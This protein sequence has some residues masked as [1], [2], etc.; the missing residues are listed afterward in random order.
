MARRDTQAINVGTNP[1]DGTGEPIRE[2]FIKVNDSF[3]NI[4]QRLIDGNLPI[5]VSNVITSNNATISN[6]TVTD[7]ATINPTV[8]LTINPSVIGSIDNTRIGQNT[9]RPGT[10][11]TLTAD[12]ITS[13][14]VVNIIGNLVV[15][16]NVVTQSSSDLVILDSII[17]LHTTAGLTPLTV[18]DGKDIGI[19]FHYYKSG[20]N[21]AFLGWANDTGSLE[22]YAAGN[23]SG[24]VFV[25]TSY[26][27]IKAGGFLSTN[28]TPSTSTSTGAIVTSGG[29]GVAGAIY[30]GSLNTGSGAITG[31]AITGTSSNMTTIY[32]TNFS[33]GNA[34][35][36]GGS[37]SGVSGA[38]GTLVVTNFS[39]GNAQISG[40]RAEGL[41][42]LNAT[43]FSTSNAQIGGGTISAMTSLTATTGSF[44]N[45]YTTNFSS[46]NVLISGGSLNGTS[47]G[48]TTAST[49]RFTTVSATTSVASPSYLWSTNSI[50]ILDSVN[51]EITNLWSNIS[52]LSSGAGSSAT[53]ITNLW[54]NAASQA[55]SINTLTSNAA[56]QATA[57]NTLDA[58]LGTA[59]TNITTLFSNA[60]T[61]STAIA[62]KAPIDN[63]SFTTHVGVTGNVDVTGYV[64]ATQD[65]IAFSDE[66]YK[67]NVTTI[68][69]AL[70]TV[71]KL[72]GVHYDR[73]D[74]GEPGTGVIAQESLSHTPRLVRKTDSGDLAV[75]YGNHAGYFIE[76]IKELADIVDNMAQEIHLLK[77][78][79]K[80]LK[81]E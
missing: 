3:G 19:K 74:T 50:S 81:G 8:S 64:I 32:T 34:V 24:G 57:L 76:A 42:Y 36:S 56:S 47:V 16:G 73:T 4:D 78:E 46:G 40:G 79:I 63:P 26:G 17:N 65:I 12:T 49:G 1:N 55:T 62:L 71:R 7:R 22:Y 35:I 58:N 68:T 23:E 14:G 20:D 66:K 27:T 60:A 18:D 69:N 21:H 29:L 28:S 75:A 30:A 59:T 25:G 44:T 45:L 10:F 53:D 11:T 61:Q 43:N 54:S 6:L 70:S 77:N 72:R 38:M 67:T 52:G 15:S 51:T 39:S 13:N 9:P 2:G 31:G 80:Q 37:V 48:G 41:L 5:V 33:T